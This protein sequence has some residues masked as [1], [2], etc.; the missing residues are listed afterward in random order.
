M[1]IGLYR[2]HE[3]IDTA[4]M[5][6]TEAVLGQSIHI[7]SVYRAWNTCRIENDRPWLERI[8]GAC[9]DI[10]LT[11]EPWRLP[12]DSERPWNQPRFSYENVLA[13][14]F[15]SYIRDFTRQ[16]NGFHQT[17]YLRFMHEMNGNWYPWGG[18]VNSNRVDRYVATW[19]HVHQLVNRYAT[20]DIQWVWCPYAASCPDT[21]NNAIQQYYPGNDVVD[22]MALDGYNWGVDGPG[23]GWQN[24][25]QIFRNAYEKAILLG[26]RPMMIAEIGCSE[27]GGDKAAWIAD[28]FQQLKSSFP[29]IQMVVWFDTDKECDWRIASSQRSLAAFR[30]T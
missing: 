2:F 3:I 15:D 14:D 30:N 5:A 19:H 1:K 20:C 11:W 24:F 25:N 22:W 6:E 28:S 10:M 8:Q 17:I 16:L 26:D 4:D 18:C 7:I 9:R 29:R 21:L 23:S 13:G 12:A 27:N